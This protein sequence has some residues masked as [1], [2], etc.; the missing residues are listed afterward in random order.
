VRLAPTQP[1][2]EAIRPDGG[3]TA[4]RPVKV[5]EPG[6]CDFHFSS[7]FQSRAESMVGSEEKFNSGS[8]LRR[9]LLLARLRRNRQ[10]PA[11]NRFYRTLIE[12][13]P[14]LCATDS[15]PARMPDSD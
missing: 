11:S 7:I 4:H 14:E 9:G 8:R 10:R 13:A 15:L 2:L 6:N 12:R 1:Q 3:L 5:L